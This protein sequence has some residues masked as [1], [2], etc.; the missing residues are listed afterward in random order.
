MLGAIIFFRRKKVPVI[1]YVD[2]IIFGFVPA[3]ILG[4]AGCT[5]VFDHPGKETDF[6]LGMMHHAD[7]VVRHNLGL[8]EMILAVVLT[9]VLYSLKNVRP[10]DGFHPA[11]M[12]LL[13][14]PVRYYL[15]GLRE[16]PRH[17]G[18]TRYLGM[19]P[20]QYF[21]VAMAAL[22]LYLIVAGLRGRRKEATV[23]LPDSTKPKK[24][25]RKRGSA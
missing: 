25:K 20:G 15:D 10:F 22:A 7:K 6:V 9:I 8:Y 2:S 1:K 21:A 14:S 19:T 18:D 24:S 23:P 3:W 4:R 5:L 17:G 16:V 12:L 13:Y 11:V